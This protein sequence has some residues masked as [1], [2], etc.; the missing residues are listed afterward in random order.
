[1]ITLNTVV[2]LKG[3]GMY[4]SKRWIKFF[5]GAERSTAADGNYFLNFFNGLLLP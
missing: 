2:W 4:V 3:K 1:V 5:G